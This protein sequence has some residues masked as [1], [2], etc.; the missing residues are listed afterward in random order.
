MTPTRIR[1]TL[2]AY[3]NRVW[4]WGYARF[5]HIV[6]EF[7]PRRS[8]PRREWDAKVND[9]TAVPEGEAVDLL[10]LWALEAY[11]PAEIDKLYAGLHK[12]GW[13]NSLRVGDGRESCIEWVR[14]Q[15]K[16]GSGGSYNVGVVNRRGAGGFSPDGL[17][18]D[19][20][21]RVEYLI[22]KL[23]QICPSLTF[24][25]IL[26]ALD[27]DARKFYEVELNSARETTLEPIRETCG[28]YTHF[29]P[30]SHKERA[31][32]AVRADW[33]RRISVWVS[34]W[35]PGLFCS[36]ANGAVPTAECVMTA[37]V[38][39]LENSRQ[40]ARPGRQWCRAITMRFPY[41]FWKSAN[42]DAI[43]VA[44]IGDAQEERS[45]VLIAV[46]Q[47]RIPE[48]T[49]K[50]YGGL[51]PGGVISILC[52]TLDRVIVH[53]GL[54][55]LLN[56]FRRRLLL[57]RDALK[58]VQS[59][60]RRAIRTL[61]YIQEFFASDAQTPIILAELKFSAEEIG[62]YLWWGGSGFISG[63]ARPGVF[64]GDLS[65]YIRQITRSVAERLL[66]DG[67]VTRE[68]LLQLSD[69]VSAR[70][71]VKAQRT[72]RR[73]TWMVI[74]LSVATVLFTILTPPPGK[75]W[76]EQIGVGY[77]RV[78][79]LIW[80]SDKTTGAHPDSHRTGLPFWARR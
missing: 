79:S 16:R 15:R 11:G 39:V 71:S 76:L 67:Q 45:H 19:L 66:R 14:R 1:K 3:A 53:F 12:L 74:F 64:R 54:F 59:G 57:T 51:N 24:A 18:A 61:D 62:N 56:S 22:V 49:A 6:P 55:A 21:D 78:H 8:P 60:E 4:W 32:K 35:L 13:D 2:R 77:E 40:E 72:M 63:D 29:D 80:K 25:Q 36:M 65:E 75:T 37:D 43:F 31:I 42:N 69:V 73:L 28:A 27:A 26:F 68:G 47:R 52:D 41:D 44:P 17:E 23:Y 5:P 58:T 50:S 48:E 38:N 30:Y 34:Q 70:V 9:E 7:Y 20:P 33:Q 46:S 10:C